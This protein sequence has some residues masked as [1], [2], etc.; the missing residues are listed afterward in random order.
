MELQV[1]KA[2][3]HGNTGDKPQILLP[4]DM[5]QFPLFANKDRLC[6]FYCFCRRVSVIKTYCF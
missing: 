6:I 4:A 2:I 3:N 5:F 1:P